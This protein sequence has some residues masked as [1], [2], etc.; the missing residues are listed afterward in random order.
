MKTLKKYED[1]ICLAIKI[2]VGCIL[3]YLVGINVLQVITRYFVDRVVT[4]IEDVSILGILWIT[5]LGVPFAWFKSEHL[6]MDITEHFYPTWAKR[7]CWWIC[8]IVCLVAAVKL[9]ELGLYSMELNRGVKAT[10]LGYDESLRYLTMVVCGIL[11]SIAAIFKI[12]ERI[13]MDKLIKK[14]RKES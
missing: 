7:F 2:I 12:I 4:W 5:A 9:I 3:L 1:I 14:E 8:Q 6:E 10:A 11:L 13:L